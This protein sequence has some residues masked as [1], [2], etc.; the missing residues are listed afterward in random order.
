MSRT[1]YS[2]E[3][4]KEAA[5]LIIIDGM[6]V[7]D[8]SKKLG[9][10]PAQLYKWRDAHLDSLSGEAA[11]AGQA[12]PKE[13]AAELDSLRKQLRKSERMNEILKKTVSYFSRDET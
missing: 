12:S 6:S 2:Q 11:A 9:A 4:K 10:S 7:S 5:R 13:M 8:V 1:R 3:F